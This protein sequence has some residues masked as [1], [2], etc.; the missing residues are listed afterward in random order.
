LLIDSERII[1]P[2]EARIAQCDGMTEPGHAIY[3][4]S[5]SVG[6]RQSLAIIR[7][8]VARDET[9]TPQPPIG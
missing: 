3:Y 1:A 7:A 2:I 9:L 6:L 8:E 5:V 4:P